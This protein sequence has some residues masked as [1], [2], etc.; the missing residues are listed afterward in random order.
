ML[1][2]QSPNSKTRS[3][4]GGDQEWI[5]PFDIVDELSRIEGALAE[6][7]AP[8]FGSLTQDSQCEAQTY[9]IAF[10]NSELGWGTIDVCL[11]I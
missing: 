5:I 3:R 8:F 10:G 6:A 7:G 2:I 11:F 4:P 9:G 1:T